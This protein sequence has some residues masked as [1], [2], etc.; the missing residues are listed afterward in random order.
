MVHLFKKGIRQQII[1]PMIIATITAVVI[2]YSFLI[3]KNEKNIIDASVVF[4]KSNIAQYL[5]LR[6]YYTN[7][8]V[9]TVQNHSELKIDILVKNSANTIPLPATMIHD[10]SDLLKE[11]N[12]HIQLNLYSK[13]PFPSRKNRVLDSFEKESL[14]FL[15]ENPTDVFFKRE[16]YENQDSVRVVVADVM[17]SMTCVNCHNSIT[18]SPKTNWKL[19][20]VR[21]ALEIIVPIENIIAINTKNTLQL[22]LLVFLILLLLI[23]TI[24]LF[25]NKKILKNIESISA[26]VNNIK[27]GNLDSQLEIEQ[28]NEFQTLSQNINSMRLSLKQTLNMLKEENITRKEAQNEL[29]TL[30]SHLEEK[31]Q[32]RTQELQIKNNT[33]SHILEELRN[34]QNNLLESKKMAELGELVGSVTHEINTPLGTGITT[35]SYIESLTKDIKTLYSKEDMTQENFENYLKNIEESIS[36][37]LNSLNRVSKMIISFKHIAVDQAIEDKRVFYVK[38]YMEEILLTLRNKTKK[39]NHK[40][41]LDIH[42]DIHINSYPGYFYQIITNFINNSYLHGFEGIEN[43]NITIRVTQDEK[44]I[45]LLYSD[46]G[47]GLDE[48]T[49][50]RLFEEY[51]TT[52][53]GKGGTGLGLTIV[54]EIVLQKLKGNIEFES[55]KN[56]GLKYTITVPK[57]N[58]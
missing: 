5:T 33:L 42:E 3:Y 50:N 44:N 24:Y 14:K 39:Y 7:K 52:K 27:N 29:D 45:Q 11:K 10:L 53:K 36:M 1:L 23:F 16:T 6:K 18:T 47:I 34:T 37:V 9:N 58:T 2:I 46:D 48:T 21:G 22:T 51:Y 17:S 49:K 13:Y 19:N 4:A 43:G 28:E 54:Q 26:F 8:I 15:E 20:D 31:I 57:N 30:N 40:I 38:E 12:A 25:L 35:S 55:K 41:T 32:Y 56:E